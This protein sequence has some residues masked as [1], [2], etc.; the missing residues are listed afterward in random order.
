MTTVVRKTKINTL[1]TRIN[2][3]NQRC[4]RNQAKRQQK[5]CQSRQSPKTIFATSSCRWYSRHHSNTNE[6]RGICM[7]V[8]SL[9]RWSRK[10]QYNT[11]IRRG[12]GMRGSL[13]LKSFKRPYLP[14]SQST[15]IAQ[16]RTLTSPWS[17]ARSKSLN[18][19][20]QLWC[21]GRFRPPS[22]ALTARASH[23]R[24]PQSR[25]SSLRSRVI[26]I[27]STWNK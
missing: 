20:K 19:A 24:V 21:K 3:F 9:L 27:F 4:V 13:F 18:C 15:S 6:T 16:S 25:W 11:S 12:R 17:T 22:S 2:L 14:F 7:L 10:H 26:A 23:V 1:L 5:P 8:S